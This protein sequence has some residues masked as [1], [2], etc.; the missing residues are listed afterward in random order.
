MKPLNSN[1]SK[2]ILQIQIVNDQEEGLTLRFA[3][4]SSSDEVIVQVLNNS[5]K[6]QNTQRQDRVNRGE[7]TKG[8]CSMEFYSYICVAFFAIIGCFTR[9][10]LDRLV[11]ISHANIEDPQSVIFQSFFSNMLGSFILG[12]LVASSL[13][14]YP[15][16]SAI[17][18]GISTG[19][20]FLT[21]W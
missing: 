20:I 6:T 17:Y 9:I 10:G 5:S 13:K 15:A 18:T 12:L 1:A 3:K 7:D 21:V 8:C 16:M 14:K 19:E 4:M 11:G 2:F